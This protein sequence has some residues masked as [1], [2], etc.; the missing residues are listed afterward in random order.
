MEILLHGE[1]LSDVDAKLAEQVVVEPYEFHLSDGTVQLALFHAVERV[2]DSEFTSPAG[3][4][5]RRDED[6]LDVVTTEPGHLVDDG[7]HAGDV[8]FS[9]LARQHV[10][11]YFD[12]DTSFHKMSLI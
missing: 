11:T 3:Y 12:Y 8:E 2:V 9:V 10:G 7:R 6:D 1:H 5:T 4:G